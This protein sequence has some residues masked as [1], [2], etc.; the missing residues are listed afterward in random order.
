GQSLSD[1]NQISKLEGRTGLS[2]L[3]GMAKSIQ[4]AR[5]AAHGDT[6]F[7][8]HMK[9]QL[10]MARQNANKEPDKTEG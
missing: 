3:S 7:R 2:R 10:Q 1:A 4:S 9:E 6:P 8:A 5:Q